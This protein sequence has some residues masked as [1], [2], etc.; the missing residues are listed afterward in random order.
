MNVEKAVFEIGYLQDLAIIGQRGVAVAAQING[1][2]RVVALEQFN[3]CAGATQ[4]IVFVASEIVEENYH[5]QSLAATQC[6]KERTHLDPVIGGETHFGN[7]IEP[8]LAFRCFRTSDLQT[9]IVVATA[10]ER[11]PQ[12]KPQPIPAQQF[13]H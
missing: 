5:G 11:D 3:I 13:A 6:A 12:K 10:R 8:A 4:P 7:R 1:Q 9:G 2:H